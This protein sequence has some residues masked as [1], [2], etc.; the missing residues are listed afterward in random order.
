MPTRIRLQRHGKKGKPFYQ[1]VIA[2]SRSKRDGKY[3]DNIGSYNPNTNPATIELNF[4]SAV[5]WIQ[6][7]AQPSDTMRAILSYKGVMMYDHLMRGVAKGAFTEEVAK[8]KF[9]NWQGDKDGKIQGKKDSLATAKEKKDAEILAAEVEVNAKRAADIA[10]KNKP[11][12]PEVE[13]ETIEEVSPAAE[14][15]TEEKAAE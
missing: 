3:I 10:A 7:G 8:E 4:E 9:A 11:E 6:K 2:D 5:N 12:E 1:I 14:E 13:E 15:T